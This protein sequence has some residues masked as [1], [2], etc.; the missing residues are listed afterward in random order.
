MRVSYH[1]GVGV[2]THSQVPLTPHQ[3]LARLNRIDRARRGCQCHGLEDRRAFAHDRDAADLQAKATAF[4]RCAEKAGILAAVALGVLRHAALGPAEDADLE[5]LLLRNETA[6]V[7]ATT[8][9]CRRGGCRYRR[10]ERRRPRT[11]V[12]RGAVVVV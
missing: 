7:S 1:I 11:I 10:R 4:L 6:V 12:V 3:E 9:D 8:H 5:G 2:V